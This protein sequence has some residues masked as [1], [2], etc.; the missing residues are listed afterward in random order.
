MLLQ[1]SMLFCLMNC[2]QPS[3]TL[4]KLLPASSTGVD[5]SNTITETDSFNILTH[6]YIYNGGGVAVADFNKDGLQ[7]LFFTGNEVPNKLYLNKGDLQFKDV[8]QRSHGKCSRTMEL[9]CCRRRYKRRR[10]AGPLRHCHHEK[11]FCA[12]GKHALFK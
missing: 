9:R 6:E 2:N 10:M 4:F 3:D 11:G 7:D 1:T 8:S 12:A 5:F